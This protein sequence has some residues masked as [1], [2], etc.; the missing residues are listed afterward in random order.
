MR[1]ISGISKGKRLY[2][3]EGMS[4]RPTSDKIK[5]SV[6][7]II[8]YIEEDSIVLDLFAGTGSVG[9][10]FLARGAKEC[11]FVDASYK[12][13]NYVK[14]NVEICNFKDKAK[15]MQNDYEKAIESFCILNQKFD[16]IFA[17]PPYDLL[18]CNNIAQKILQNKLLKK[19][20]LLIIESDKSEE[21]FTNLDYED[22]KYKEKI[23]GRTRISMIKLLE[24]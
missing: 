4:V 7:N 1:I 12:S 11:Y 15:I 16:Y 2:A 14:K 8:G 10:E 17:D 21:I 20:G 18:C 19:N 22:V 13:L 5:E 3:P 6:F 9:I 23:Y 24:D